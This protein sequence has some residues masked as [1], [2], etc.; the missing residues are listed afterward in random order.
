MLGL[1][2]IG[3]L[4]YCPYLNKYEKILKESRVEYEVLYWNRS[5]L[6]GDCASGRYLGYNKASELKKS[7]VFKI[8]DFWNFRRWLKNIISQKNYEKII[9]LSSLSGILLYDVVLKKYRRNYIFDIRDYSYEKIGLYYLMEKKLIENSW[10]TTISSKEFQSFL[11]KSNR[12]LY[13][14]N[15]E[16]EPFDRKRIFLKRKKEKLNFVWLGALRY[17]N[18]Q[19]KIIEKL[20]QDGRFNIIFHGTGPEKQLF[21]NFVQERKLRNV[22]FTGRYNNADKEKLLEEADIINNSYETSMET[23]YAVSNKFYDGIQY[24][25]PQLVE[26]N[27]YKARLIEQYPVGIAIDVSEAGFSEKLYEYYESMKEDKF[28]QACDDLLQRFLLEE[29]YCIKKIKEFILP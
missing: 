26:C 22:K 16:I 5:N 11:P 3:D 12:Y 29:N 28:N 6:K 19:A 18:H 10:F 15:M 14:H 20:D 13:T 7:P 27:S 2:F 21:E 17:F 24:H 25:I 1:I 23:K 9:L 4:I 8:K